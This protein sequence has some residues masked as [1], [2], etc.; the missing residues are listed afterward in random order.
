MSSTNRK[1][2]TLISGTALAQVVTFLFSPILSRFFSPAEFGEF[3]VYMGAVN[4]IQVIACGRYEMAVV[5][6]DDDTEAV[7]VVA[8]SLLVTLGFALLCLLGAASSAFYTMYDATFL[9]KYPDMQNWLWAMPLFILLLGAYMAL[10]QWLIRKES[11]KEMSVG[12]FGSSA[13]SSVLQ[14]VLGYAK[15]GANG[16]T[17]G[18]IAGHAV[19][20]SLLYYYAQK[21]RVAWWLDISWEKVK[22]VALRYQSLPRTTLFQSLLEMFQSNAL[23]WLLPF[24]YTP[25]E[26]GFYFRTL[27]IFQAPVALVAQAL[28]QVAYREAAELHHAGESLKPLVISTLKK[29]ALLGLPICLGLIA[30]G[31]WAFSTF[32]GEK[33]YEAGVYAR[34]LAVWM[35][36]DFLRI[37]LA[38]IAIVVQKQRQ[39]LQR[40]FIGLI[41]LVSSVSAGYY[42]SNDVHLSLYLLSG[43]M[44]LFMAYLLTWFVANV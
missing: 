13:T 42:I 27:I 2:L 11:Y 35:Y 43:G 8:L 29:S 9:Q 18:A 14:A 32:F 44:T 36:L 34:I 17:I 39:L 37:P 7:N 23:L 25:V 21:N 1:L 31:P 24:F 10:N 22:A 12:R 26:G 41:V 19:Y 28:A 15:F 4:A 3:A 30:L 6:A 33:W 40:S 20:S 5:L 38:Q 16:I